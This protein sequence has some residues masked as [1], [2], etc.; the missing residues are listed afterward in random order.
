MKKTYQTNQVAKL[1][2]VHP[3]TVR[4]YEK[5]GLITKANRM[6]NGYRSFTQLQLDQFQLARTAFQIEILQNGLRKK[7]VEIV[8]LSA[9]CEFEQ[10]ME[11]TKNYISLLQKERDQAKEAVNLVEELLKEQ[12]NLESIKE[13]MPSLKRK[14][15]SYQLGISMDTLRN[16][17]MNGLI[18]VK[19][20]EN[21]YRVYTQEDI[22]IIKIIRSLKCANYS[23]SSILRMLQ[24]LEVPGGRFSWPKMNQENR[25]PGLTHLEVFLNQDQE[26]ENILTACDKLN[27]SLIN[28]QNNAWEMLSLL[29]TMNEKYKL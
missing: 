11:E 9:S 20:K 5:L 7:V 16:W 10:A 14:E 17:E 2:G 1:I 22:I 29:Q 8:K 15:V 27:I 19:R 18:R 21:G 12:G 3:N 26:E 28:A 4:L 13:E 25:P 6:D 23:L 24:V